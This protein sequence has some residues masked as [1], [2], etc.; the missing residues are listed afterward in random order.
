VTD[1]IPGD[2]SRSDGRY[3]RTGIREV[4]TDVKFSR[5]QRKLAIHALGEA[6]EQISRYYCIPPHRWQELRYDFL[7][8]Q[9]TEWEPLPEVILARVQRLE[10][11]IRRQSQPFDFY[12][13]Q[14]NDPSILTA[15]KREN[16]GDDFY[17]FLVFILTHEMVHLVRLSTI[18]GREKDH[19][20]SRESEEDRVQ[21]VSRQILSNR[22]C[23]AFQLILDRFCRPSPGPGNSDTLTTHGRR[24][25]DGALDRAIP[26]RKPGC[27][28]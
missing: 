3:C 6:E 18:I 7:T 4:E 23:E 16:L 8:R 11:I 15:A 2:S 27:C 20:L 5:E 14:L 9:D 12:R 24:R 13:I 1:S 17:Q 25:L 22:R 26:I 19:T 10:K 21:R 28:N